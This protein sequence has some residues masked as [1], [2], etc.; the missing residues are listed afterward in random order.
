MLHSFL[1]N[2]IYS[3]GTKLVHLGK[4]KEANKTKNLSPEKPW[5][6]IPALEQP[7]ELCITLTSFYLVFN[8]P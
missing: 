1:T 4:C 3:V 2:N 7:A 5:V 6:A 8:R